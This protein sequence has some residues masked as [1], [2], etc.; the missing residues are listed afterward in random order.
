MS[1]SDTAPFDM[2]D[3]FLV[4]GMHRSGT[5][6]VAGMLTK[7]GISAP[8]TPMPANEY[9]ERG[10]FESASFMRLHD[11]L[12]SSAG[13]RWDDWRQFNPT[14]YETTIAGSFRDR[15]L[16]L[17]EAEFGG[18]PAFV[19]KDP[20][21]CRFAPFWFTVLKKRGITPNVIIPIRSPLEVALSL[22]KRD[23]FPLNTGL[24]LW[25]RHVLDAEYFS[26][27]H[28]RAIVRWPDLLKDWRATMTVV[29]K[30]IGQPWPRLSDHVAVE[31]DTYLSE[32]LRHHEV[33][34]WELKSHSDVHE[35]FLPTYNALC[36]L[37][38]EPSSNS[39]R[40][41]LDDIRLQFERA[42]TLFGLNAANLEAQNAQLRQSLVDL[43]GGRADL[44]ARHEATLAQLD[45]VRADASELATEISVREGEVG[46]MKAEIAGLTTSRDHWEARHA[47]AMAQL[48]VLRA[49]AAKICAVIADN[50]AE[51]DSA[52]GEIARLTVSCDEW[53]ARYSVATTQLDA[54]RT[55]TSEL[56]KEISHRQAELESARARIVDLEVSRDEW[57]S[58]AED[59]QRAASEWEARHAEAAAQLVAPRVQPSELAAQISAKQ[60]G[61]DSKAIGQ[62]ATGISQVLFRIAKWPF[63]LIALH[64]L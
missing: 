42:S 2:K 55:E 59:H 18:Q 9:N 5:S 38:N 29:A 22:R 6:T 27:S 36:E 33:A 3:A 28:Q 30:V 61:I 25:L 60:E 44:A 62:R 35:W 56:A 11:D 7:L 4:L 52:K 13:T 48:D 53:K 8:A 19:L 1:I 31:I 54:I 10:Y 49:E 32:A 40:S 23:S 63:L 20:R 37:A 46:S 16:A 34:D 47:D 50:K 64:K 14:W 12:L 15:A 45:R 51:L 58:R 26:R 24:L 43:E 41:A 17:L 39:A 57:V 21:C